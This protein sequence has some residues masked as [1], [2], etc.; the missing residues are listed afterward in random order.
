[1]LA[2]AACLLLAQ[3]PA[4]AAVASGPAVAPP[5]PVLAPA[6]PPACYP[7]DEEMCCWAGCCPGWGWRSHGGLPELPWASDWSV[8]GSIAAYF[9][10]NASGYNSA[11]ETAAGARL[12]IYGIG[13]ELD[14]I[15]AHLGV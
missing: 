5:P 6:R 13:W 7:G 10:G 11:Q 15:P 14:N 12:G 4:A 3:L 2:A 1:M 8:N 9:V